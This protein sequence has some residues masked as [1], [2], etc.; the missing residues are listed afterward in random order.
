[1]E[2]F[3]KEGKKLNLSD[4]IDKIDLLTNIPLMK[5]SRVEVIDNQGRSYVNWEQNNNVELSIQDIGRT[6]K[7]FI[8]NNKK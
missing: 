5:V 4:I 8:N 7:V 6:L 1:M 3:D 2:I